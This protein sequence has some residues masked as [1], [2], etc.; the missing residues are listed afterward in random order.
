MLQLSARI[1]SLVMPFRHRP[2][3]AATDAPADLRPVV[4]GNAETERA[5]PL[6]A[7]WAVSS[8]GLLCCGWELRPAQSPPLSAAA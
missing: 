2:R 3:V 6:T 4:G 7:C 5:C 8:E 1:R